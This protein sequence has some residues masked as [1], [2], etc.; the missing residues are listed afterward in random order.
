MVIGKS[1]TGKSTSLHRFNANEVGVFSCAGKRLPFRKRLKVASTRDYETIKEALTRNE[2]R[3]YVIDDSTYLMQFENFDRASEKGY[4][5]YTQM[6]VHFKELLD[7]AKFTSPDT[8]VYFLMHPELDSLGNEKPKTI[9]KMLDEK[10]CVEGLFETVLTAKVER[11]ADNSVRYVFMTRPDGSGI[12]KS[13]YDPETGE[14]M[15]PAVMDNDLKAV[16]E[17]I[18]AWYGMAPIDG[19]D[20]PAENIEIPFD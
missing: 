20:A 9:G 11:G 6:A 5:K 16:D 13:P 19:T 4:D 7:V 10:L 12:T 8:I 18:R 14:H 17:A 15:L 1:G 3:A 2:M